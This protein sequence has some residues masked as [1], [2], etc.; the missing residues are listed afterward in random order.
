MANM[1]HCRFEN[2]AHG[3][4]Q[5]IHGDEGFTEE[6]KRDEHNARRSLIFL[7]IQALEQCGYRVN[8]EDVDDTFTERM[9]RS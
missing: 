8:D 1:H 6:L 5:I 4:S 2:T 3:L 7:M 9:T